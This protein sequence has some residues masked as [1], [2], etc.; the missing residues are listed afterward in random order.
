MV[1]PP[2]DTVQA[3]SGFNNTPKVYKANSNSGLSPMK[4]ELTGLT[5]PSHSKM[6]FR[7]PP[8]PSPNPNPL[9]NP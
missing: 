3:S 9:L 4:I 6:V 2:K 7:I 8:R 1:L 5:E